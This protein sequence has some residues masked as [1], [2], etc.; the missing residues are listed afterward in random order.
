MAIDTTPSQV[1]TSE[2]QA[3][4]LENENTS[5]DAG[6]AEATLPNL[7]LFKANAN[8]FADHSSKK[9]STDTQKSKYSVEYTM[10]VAVKAGQDTM[11]AGLAKVLELLGDS[12]NVS[13]PLGTLEVSSF[14]LK[15]SPGE[16]CVLIATYKNPDGIFEPS[17]IQIPGLQGRVDGD[18]MIFNLPVVEGQTTS[19]TVG[20]LGIDKKVAVETIDTNTDQKN[21]K[22]AKM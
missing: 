5:I 16:T 13:D 1:E 20:V 19:F 22:F 2:Q 7:G 6:L 4:P 12:L 15:G 14:E 8:S 11:P 3:L 18:S 9:D 21:R 17:K 10:D